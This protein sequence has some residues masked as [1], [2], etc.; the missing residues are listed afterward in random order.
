MLKNLFLLATLPLH[1]IGPRL[2][3]IEAVY[4]RATN[5]WDVLVRGENCQLVKEIEIA[6]ARWWDLQ[7]TLAIERQHARE[8][9]KANK[10][11]IEACHNIQSQIERV[12]RKTEKR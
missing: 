12:P 3:W 1:A 2:S 5:L 6:Y 10:A 11:L 8:I 4:W 7:R 9:R